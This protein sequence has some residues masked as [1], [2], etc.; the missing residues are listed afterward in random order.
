[1][2]YNYIEM[3]LKVRLLK[4]HILVISR[5]EDTRLT[6]GLTIL[7]LETHDQLIIT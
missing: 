6:T 1:M 7:Q 2:T 4:G 5:L 3:L